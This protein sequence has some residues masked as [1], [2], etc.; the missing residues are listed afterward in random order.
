MNKFTKIIS[1]LYSA[2]YTKVPQKYFFHISHK[3][4]IHF[5]Q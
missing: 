4:Y 2:K 3:I 5:I 1:L